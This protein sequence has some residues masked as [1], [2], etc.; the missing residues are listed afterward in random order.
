MTLPNGFEKDLQQA[1]GSRRLGTLLIDALNDAGADN[2]STI[3]AIV[4][5]GGTLTVTAGTVN[6][7]DGA[8]TTTI[9]NGGFTVSNSGSNA[10]ISTLATTVGVVAV[11]HTN[12]GWTMTAGASPDSLVE[13][14]L[15]TTGAYSTALTANLADAWSVTDGT[16]DLIVFVTTTNALSVSLGDTTSISG[17]SDFRH[18]QRVRLLQDFLLDAGATLPIPFVK[19]VS[20]G[21][22]D[23]VADAINGEYALTHTGGAGAETMCLS[24]AD[25]L[26]IDPTKKPMMEVRLKINFAGATFTAD[27]RIVIGFA[28]A[29][30]ATLDDIASNVWFR[31]EGASLDIFW[32]T[33]DGTTDD[34]DNN[35]AI[36]IV[37]DT[38]LTLRIDM[39]SLSD[40]KF[41]I[42]NQLT[43]GGT[44][45]APL[46]TAAQKLQPYI[47]IQRDGGAEA[48][49]VTIDYI[50]V[51]WDRV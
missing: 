4:P 32:E 29:R 18:R 1:L 5:S 13:S 21:G 39:S 50:D 25:Q 45:A 3:N 10:V 31:I 14:I 49:V 26:M 28:S 11:E 8:V 27:Q 2:S 42:N 40:I 19:T 17:K 34:N 22:G 6:F 30:N 44:A 47:E 23:F 43:G 35:T 36:D 12:V 20:G 38:F 46:L 41:Y 24:W 16:T 7:V 51:E 9:D 37:D 48:E 15:S 33:D